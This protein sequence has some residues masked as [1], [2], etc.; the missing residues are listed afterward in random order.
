MIISLTDFFHTFLVQNQI[1]YVYIFIVRDLWRIIMRFLHTADWHIGKT[2]N[3]F[4]LLADQQATFQQIEAIAQEQQVDAVVIAG[5]L[6]DRS[7]PNEAS[8]KA[9]NGMLQQLNL[10]DHFPVLAISGNH[11]SAPRLSTGADWFAYQSFY[12]STDLVSAFTPIT[13]LDTQFFL[14]PFFGIQEV[15]NYFHDDQIKNI[16]DAMQ[17]IVTEMTKYFAPAKHHV[18]VTHFFA[19]GSKRTADSETLIEVGGLSAVTTDVLAP[20][21]Y[22]ALGHLHNH[23]ALQDEKIK[24]SGSP[25]KF[26]VSEAK[27]EKGVWLVDTDPF[28]TT[29]IPLQPVHDIHLLKGA[30]ADLIASA[31]QYSPADFYDIELTDQERIPDVLNKLREYFPKIVSLHRTH[32]AQQAQLNLNRKR[33]QESPMDLL[34]DFYTQTM[35]NELTNR[36]KKWAT[37]A[38]AAVMKEED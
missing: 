33:V 8:V 3:D 26:S 30:F 31:H 10:H 35:G 17:K 9:L 29:W 18:L 32:Q 21:D 25:M 37:E 27:Q 36:Q 19:A 22:V 4:N 28:Q 1:D 2:L 15:R 7:I 6:Y 14:L 34:A 16:N 12:L 38:L 20:F 13:I 5:D 11:D 24:Y 23:Q